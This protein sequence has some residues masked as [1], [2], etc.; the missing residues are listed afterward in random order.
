MTAAYLLNHPEH[1]EHVLHTNHQNYRKPPAVERAKPLMGRSMFIAEAELWERQRKLIQPSFRRKNLDLLSERILGVVGD[2]LQGWDAKSK[3]PDDFNLS[4]D[5]SALTIEIMVRTFFGASLEGD[6]IKLYDA[7]QLISEVTAK[8]VWDVTTLATKLPTRENREYDLALADINNVVAA[9]I[10][11]RRET[12]SPATDLLGIFL[13]ACDPEDDASMS[14]AQ[15]QDEV[16]SLIVSGFE[17]TASL[18]VWA[19]YFLSENPHAMERVRNEADSILQGQLPTNSSLRDMQYTKRVVQEVARLRP[20]VWWFSRTAIEDDVIGGEPIRAGTTVLI[21]QYVLHKL[22]SQ[23]EDPERFDPDR[24][25]P[26]HAAGRSKYSYLPFGAGPCVSLGSSLSMMEMQIILPL[27][28]RKFDVSITSDL[29]P[30]LGN[31]ISLKP[32]DDLR[33]IVKARMRH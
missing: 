8:R 9:I 24:F 16:V 32:K 14:D 1:V 19:T 13:N 3:L 22:P 12:I 33:A 29:N 20:T 30:D 17:S 4:E 21:S 25:L 10:R 26:E 18:L 7:M 5:M 15:L 6:G 31:F 27:I 28:Y 2:H 11:G 23:W